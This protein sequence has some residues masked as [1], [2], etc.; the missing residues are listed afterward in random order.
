MRLAIVRQRYNP[1]GGAE[2]F[3]ERAASALAGRL[4]ITV[5]AREWA[6]SGTAPVVRCAPFHIGRLWRDTSFARQVCRKLASATHDLVQS[7]ERIACC[8]VYR[9]GDG[10]HASW[11]DRRGRA[12][13]W[14][15]RITMKLNPYHRYVLAAERRM[16]EG[17]RLKAVIC[18]SQMVLDE[19]RNRFAIDESKLRVVYNGVD[20]DEFNP[21]CKGEHRARSRAMLGIPEESTV[22]LFV[23]SGFERKGV[24]TL[25]RAFARLGDP[26]S[27]LV[28]VGKDKAAA[29]MQNLARDLGISGRVHFAGPQSALQ[30]WYGLSDVFVLPTLYDPFPNAALEALASGLP[31][32]TTRSSGIAEFVRHRENGAICEDPL[33]SDE[34]AACMQAIGP[35]AADIS[36]EARATAE[37]L[38]I[39]SMADQLVALYRE[40][41]PEAGF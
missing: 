27:W 8:D 11:L 41:V 16:F 36:A 34:L 22:Y 13:G 25:L 17:A 1:Y 40:L 29:G 12:L 24:P 39:D 5:Y 38:G 10:V 3:I 30:A 19:I 21:R 37:R 4:S 15:G 28:I 20:L 9:A 7:H 6:G 31:V 33:S 32:V 2:R 14:F 18:N 35:I 26:D 23:G